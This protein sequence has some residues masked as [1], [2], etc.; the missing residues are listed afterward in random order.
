MK[1][2]INDANILIDLVKL[3][4]VD[5]FLSLEFELHTTDFVF[6]ELSVQQQESIAHVKLNIIKMDDQQDFDAITKLLTTHN[7]LS[8]EDCSVWHYTHKLNGIL[9]TGDGILRKKVTNTGLL[10]KGI[11]YIVE[12]IKNQHKLPIAICI[13]KL[14]ELKMIN[15][16]LPNHEIDKRILDWTAEIG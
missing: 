1:I 14:K 9:I 5:A 10:V 6:A 15:N 12:E 7:G 8:F 4:I 2:L 16:R 11:I 3:D 13:E